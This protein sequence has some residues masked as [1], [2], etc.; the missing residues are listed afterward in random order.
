MLE[1]PYCGK[2]NAYEFHFGGEY[3]TRPSQNDSDNAWY[4]YVYGRSNVV[5]EQKEWWYHRFGCKRWFLATRDTLTNTVI[6]TFVP[7]G[8]IEDKERQK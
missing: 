4:E 6:S 3:L 2:R 5:G 8:Q 7:G 1:C